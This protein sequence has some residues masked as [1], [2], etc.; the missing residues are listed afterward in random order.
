MP[1]NFPVLMLFLIHFS[2]APRLIHASTVTSHS[3]SLRMPLGSTALAATIAF[4][5][6]QHGC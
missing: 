5:A 3:T 4:I 1:N 2:H 6:S